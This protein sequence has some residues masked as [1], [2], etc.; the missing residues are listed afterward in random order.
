VS[1]GNVYIGSVQD[2]QIYYGEC[3]PDG[4]EMLTERVTITLDTDIHIYEID[5]EDVLRFAAK[6]CRGIYD[7][8]GAEEGQ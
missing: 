2:D 7:R 4:E 3:L 6:H 5:L 8:V 1:S